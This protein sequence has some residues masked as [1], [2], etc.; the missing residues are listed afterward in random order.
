[1]IL[2]LIILLILILIFN[3]T[4]FFTNVVKP[5]VEIVIARYNEPLEWLKEDPYNKYPVIVY[6]KSG[7][8]NFHKSDK[9]TRVV[10]L[11]NVGREFHSYLYHIIHNYHNLADT[12]VFL[13]GSTQLPHK[14][15]KAELLFSNL[16][17]KTAIVCAGRMDD[18]KKELHNFTLD[19]YMSGDKSNATLNNTSDLSPS[20]VRPFG[21][22][23]S[24]LFGDSVTTC[25]NQNLIF[26]VSKEDILKK[27]RSYYILLI[28]ELDSHPNHETGHYFER[29]TEAVF[30]PID[31]ES[32]LNFDHSTVKV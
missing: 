27:P 18:V 28:K 6:N 15:A 13:P 29:A 1:M 3:N 20:T 7:N 14:I 8:E 22:W 5:D 23:Y 31:P 21:K 30:G 9:I 12:T 17:K 32:L 24:N 11:P 4:R 26:A 25:M 10:D 19:S 2:L 16:H